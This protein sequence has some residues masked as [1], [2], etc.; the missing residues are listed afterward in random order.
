M[1]R[2]RHLTKE[3]RFAIQIGLESGRK[4]SAIAKELNRS[5]SCIS[6]EIH[7][8]TDPDFGFYCYLR[9]DNLAR[10][11]QSQ[12][13]VRD[14]KVNKVPK[15]ILDRLF[16]E[17]M[18]VHELS[19]EDA[20]YKLRMEEEYRVS[21]STI[22]RYINR[23]RCQNGKL[24]R[25][26][27][28]K[29][30]RHKKAQFVRV[31]IKDKTIIELRP[32]K[33]LLMLEAGHYEIDTIYG[34][35]QESFLLTLVDIATMYTVIIKLD[36]KAAATVEEALIHLFSTTMLPLKSIT[37]DNGGEFACHTKI[38]SLYNIEWYFCH[39]Y[40]SWERGLNENTNGLIRRFLP[41]GT[42]F[43]LVS[44]AR[45]QFIQNSLNGRYRKRINKMTPT[46]LMVEMLQQAA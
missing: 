25:Y 8:N 20:A 33:S 36:N 26:L 30:K 35:D 42:D 18:G 44:L 13:K 3:E 40:C 38:K 14:Y 39:P 22:Y 21:Y 41:K 24:Y 17:Y 11:R 43:N 6:K 29:G 12:S 28:R 10:E 32:D 37:S 34:K 4:I 16:T 15:E 46:N 45:V 9:A 2:I 23:D 19:P 31:K 5:K 27:P 7:F 1:G